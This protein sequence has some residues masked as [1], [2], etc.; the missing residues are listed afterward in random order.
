MTKKKLSQEFKKNLLVFQIIKE[1]GP[2]INISLT[3]TFIFPRYMK[4]RNTGNLLTKKKLSQQDA[5]AFVNGNLT[6]F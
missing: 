6:I 2:T 4:A 5:Y 1:T 3:G